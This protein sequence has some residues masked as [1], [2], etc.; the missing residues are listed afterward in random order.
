MRKIRVL[1]LIDKPFLGGGQVHLLSLAKG[2]D[3]TRYE[4]GVAASGGGPLED[5]TKRAGLDF[6]AVPVEKKLGRAAVRAIADVL[7]ERRV[8]LLHTHGGVAG[9]F[10]RRAAAAAKTPVVVHTLHG[11]HYLHYRN[12]V[13]RYLFILQERHFVRTTDAVI[14]V[15]D[16]DAAAGRRYRLAP[17][18]KM[19]VIKNGVDFSAVPDPTKIR[20]ALD[21]LKASLRLTTPII[22]TVARLHRQKGVV[23]LLGAAAE[24]LS[25][26]PEA[27]IVAVGGGPE[28]KRLRELIAA[29]NL[30]NRVLLLGERSDAREIMA[31][32][33][34]FVLPSLWEGLPLALLEATALGKAI[35]AADIDGVREVLEDGTTGLLV[36]PKDPGAISAAVLRL[37]E[38]KGL[39]SKLGAAAKATIPPRFTL[40]HMIEEVDRLY[41]ELAAKKIV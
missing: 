31:L 25:R 1:E 18:A 12:P 39:S 17:E 2:L 19:K 41:F 3:K 7:A 40:K 5:E 35:V 34:V 24:I 13:L 26:Y 8:D 20:P 10:G 38:D 29:S 23:Y 14:F 21:N 16:A 32:F 22:G 9:L 28:E 36:P 33:D 30:E 6:V 27:T 15:S 11:I 4:V 37:I